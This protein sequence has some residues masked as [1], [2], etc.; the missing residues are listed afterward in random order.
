MH[1]RLLAFLI[2]LGTA[3]SAQDAVIETF[4][5]ENGLRGVVVPDGRAPAVTQMLWY[6]TGSAD[7]TPGKSGLAHFF[8]HLMFKGTDTVPEGEFSRTVAANGGSDNAFTS[9]DF[10]AYVQRIASDRLALVMQMEADRMTGL[11]LSEED[12]T[13]ERQVVL[14]ERSSRVDS[15]P[16]GIFREQMTAAAFLNHPYGRPV[17]GWR[18]EIEALTREDALAFYQRFYAPNNAVLIVA[19]DVQPG[20]VETLAR[21]LYGP[22][23]PSDL[24]PRIR[25]QE[26]PQAAPR[27]L[28]S[29][30][31]RVRQPSIMR[32][33]LAPTREPGSQ[34]KAAAITLLAQLMGGGFTSD[35]YQKL[36]LR[37]QV[38][39]SFGAYYNA[40]SLDPQAFNIFLEPAQGVPVEDA[41]AALDAAIADFLEEG[42]DEDDLARLKYRYRA[43]EIYALD[44]Q[45]A[46]AQLYGVGLCSGLGLEDIANWPDILAEV[47]VADIMQAAG[48][49]LDL[50]RS[51]TGLLLPEDT[52]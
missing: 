44:N 8:E 42:I 24:P 26:P 15:S 37:D 19:G 29:R 25:P 1:L 35:L 13:F 51:V 5:L 46:R 9:H 30:D 47:T 4:T 18:H 32:Q 2:G 22:L 28:I 48:E 52:E 12:I 10:T 49:V 38:A 45:M 34:R 11:T 21:T 20:E 16:G 6:C 39:I 3:A 40:T 43:S 17:I 14:E 36:V 27:K 33:Y 50:N 41:E 31:A 23:Q 7:E